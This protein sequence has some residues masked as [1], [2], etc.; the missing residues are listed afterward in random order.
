LAKFGK[1]RGVSFLVLRNVRRLSTGKLTGDING[2]AWE[3]KGMI[4]KRN[5]NERR[6]T[7]G[8]KRDQKSQEEKRK[9]AFH[10][11]PVVLHQEGTM[12]CRKK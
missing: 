1:G 8:R 12:I 9:G 3:E 5:V 6:S 7:V 2:E 11:K 4:G 10:E